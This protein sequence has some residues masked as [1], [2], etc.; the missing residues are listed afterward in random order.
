MGTRRHPGSATEDSPRLRGTAKVLE[1]APWEAFLAWVPNYGFEEHREF[2]KAKFEEVEEGL[3][4]K[5]SLG[6]FL[7]HCGT[8]TATAALAEI[9]EDEAKVR[10]A[11]SMRPYAVVLFRLH[12][13]V[14]S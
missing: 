1:N 6:D 10:S 12:G 4:A 2:A 9:V 3:M 7:D 13:Y 8:H 11:L 14:A 5:M